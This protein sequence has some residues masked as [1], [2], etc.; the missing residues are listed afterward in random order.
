MLV[1]SS[2]DC[3]LLLLAIIDVGPLCDMFCRRYVEM[4]FFVVNLRTYL[5]LVSTC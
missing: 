5:N 4:L 3:V 1:N 2:F